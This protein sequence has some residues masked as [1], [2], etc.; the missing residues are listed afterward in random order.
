MQASFL[1][2]T[3]ALSLQAALGPVPMLV[4]GKCHGTHHKGE[5]FPKRGARDGAQTLG[6]LEPGGVAGFTDPWTRLDPGEGWDWEGREQ[7]KGLQA[8]VVSQMEAGW[9]NRRVVW[10]SERPTSLA[11]RRPA[12]GMVSSQTPESIR[13]VRM[14]CGTQMSPLCHPDHTLTHEDTP[15]P[16][17]GTESLVTAWRVLSPTMCFPGG[18]G[19]SLLV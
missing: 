4:G 12:G 9:S 1:I 8:W 18:E 6:E 2:V 14:P 7:M 10:G 5:V 16:S 3:S 15:I 11:L 19:H 17:V 13:A